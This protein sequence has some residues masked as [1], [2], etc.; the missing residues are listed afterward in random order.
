MNPRELDTEQ[1]KEALKERIRKRPYKSSEGESE[2]CYL[3]LRSKTWGEI[4][5]PVLR[6]PAAPG[7]PDAGETTHHLATAQS[8]ISDSGNRIAE[9]ISFQLRGGDT[10]L[11]VQNAVEP[12]IKAMHE[13]EHLGPEHPTVS[14]RR[15]HLRTHISAKLA[16]QRLL[17]LPKDVVQKW[18]D[19]LEVTKWQHGMPHAQ[20]ASK[21]TRKAVYASLVALFHHHFPGQAVPFAGVTISDRKKEAKRRRDL[22]QQGRGRELIRKMTFTPDEILR[23]LLTARFIDTHPE[24]GVIADW[25]CRT[26]APLTATQLAFASRIV[27]LCN[28]LWLDI[29]ADGFAFVAGTK[30]PSA[31]RYMPLQTSVLPWLELLKKAQA[32][33]CRPEHHILRLHPAQDAKPNKDVWARRMGAVQKIAGLKIEQERSHIY[34]RTHT[35]MGTMAGIPPHEIKLLIGHSEVAGGATDVY[36]QMIRQLTRPE[37]REYIKLPS[38][39]EV[40]AILAEGWTPP[41]LPRRRG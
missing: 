35:S 13:D 11:L 4:G 2:V 27:E 5:T 8:W 31:L 39:Q 7:W 14:Q 15:S 18:L 12:Y 41:H 6:N 19:G 38:P 21:N 9:S 3:D 33:F 23:I 28:V 22:V 26:L 32:P 17:T 34:R 37:H 30:T 10:S 1:L 40:D 25:A 29:E 24:V 36:I 16:G 20:P